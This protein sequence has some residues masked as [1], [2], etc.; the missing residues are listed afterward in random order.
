METLTINYLIN[1]SDKLKKKK[2]LLPYVFSVQ[3]ETIY[4]LINKQNYT[5]NRF[6]IFLIIFECGPTW[7]GYIIWIS[8]YIIYTGVIIEIQL[9]SGIGSYEF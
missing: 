5:F 8:M 1:Y 7:H 4:Y 9:L 3:F 6:I 2:E